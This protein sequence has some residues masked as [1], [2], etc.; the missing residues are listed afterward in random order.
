MGSEKQNGFASCTN[1]EIKVGLEMLPNWKE[2]V[3]MSI[4]I[5]YYSA[6]EFDSICGDGKGLMAS[7]AMLLFGFIYYR[8]GRMF[9][10]TSGKQFVKWAIDEKFLTPQDGIDF[11]IKHGGKFGRRVMYDMVFTD[12]PLEVAK[13]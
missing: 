4:L 2:V 5:P 8:D 10:T 7:K 13:P 3:L 6:K 12:L 1:P 9:V 11:I